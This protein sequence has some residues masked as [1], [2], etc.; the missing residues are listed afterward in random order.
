MT[1][2]LNFFNTQSY[3]SLDEL[4]LEVLK[5]KQLR[6]F[7][8]RDDLLHPHISGNK[9]RKLK[10][11]LIE[12]RQQGQEQL[13]T[14]GGAYSNHIAATA[15][16]GQQFGFKTIGVIRGER[17]E[18]LNATLSFAERQGMRLKFIDRVTYRRKG[19]PEFL[20]SLRKMFGTFHHLPEG[21]TNQ[22]ATRGTG[23]IIKELKAQLPQPISHIC[24]SCGTGG[25][26]AGIIN[27][28]DTQTKVL[29]FPALKGD[30]FKKE[31]DDLLEAP[32]ENWSLILDYHFGGYAKWDKQL[33]QF[34]NDFRYNHSISL[35]PIYTGKMMYGIFDLIEKDFFKPG[36]NITIIHTGGL[37][38]IGGFN[39]RFGDLIDV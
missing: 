7:I 10:Y 26:I 17:I 2:I 22:L 35:D 3:S 8:K 20:A 34:I 39:E 30:F 19:E 27:E 29:G 28:S 13:L 12:A 15:A 21:G 1:D 32:K 24:V 23:E 11:N 16:A 33:I 25:T 36:S 4:D 31:I 5:N 37:Q 38:G 18:P 14:F 9:W 6:V